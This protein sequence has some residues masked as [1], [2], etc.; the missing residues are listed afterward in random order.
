MRS[1]ARASHATSPAHLEVGRTRVGASLLGWFRRL[2]ASVDAEA[3]CPPT[4]LV[5]ADNNAPP[6]VYALAQARL[7]PMRRWLETEGA[8]LPGSEHLIT[9]DSVLLVHVCGGGGGCVR[10]LVPSKVFSSTLCIVGTCAQFGSRADP[11]PLLHRS[12]ARPPARLPDRMHACTHPTKSTETHAQ[13]MIH[14]QLLWHTHSTIK[15]SKR[16][17]HTPPTR[18][19]ATKYCGSLLQTHWLQQQPV[20]RRSSRESTARYLQSCEHTRLLL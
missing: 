13:H 2:L 12:P 15:P 8:M 18:E 20:F 17:G 4:A 16:Q 6:S 5:I 14:T 11:Q 3:V 9:G 7:D 10:V 1:A 19:Q